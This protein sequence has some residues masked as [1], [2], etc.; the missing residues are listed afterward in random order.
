MSSY[1]A[2]KAVWS[3]VQDEFSKFEPLNTTSVVDVA[4]VGGGITGISAAYMLRKRGLSVVVLEAGRVGEGSTGSSTGNLYVPNARFRTILSKHKLEGLEAV[5]MSR[6]AAM[7]F[8]ED[9][10]NEFNIECGYR[11]VPMYYFTPW[12]RE[13]DEIRNERM[14]IQKGGIIASDLVPPDFPFPVFACTT[15]EMQAQF[16]PLQYVKKLA[17]ELNGPECVIH[18]KTKVLKITDGEPC[19][20]ETTKGVVTAR[21]VIQATHTPKGIYAVHAMMEVYREYAVA[22]RIKGDLPPDAI[23]WM[24]EGNQKYSIRTY[25]NETGSWLI[26]LDDSH[27]VGTKEKTG[28]SFKKIEKFI[29]S[30]FDVEEVSYMWAAQNYSSADS[31]PYI[32]TGPTEKNVYIATGFA[33]DGLTYGTAAA[34]IVTDLI[35][36]VGNPWAQY[37]DPKRLTIAASAKNAIKENLAVLSHLVKDYIFTGKEKKLVYVR[38]GKGKVVEISGRK[39]AAY[40]DEEGRF[41]I[42]DAV[43]PH[44]G[45]IVHWNSAEK[46]WDCPC[47]GSRFTIDGKVLEGPAINDLTQYRHGQDAGRDSGVF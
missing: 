21:H 25:S 22:L 43:C 17:A 28:K 29:R 11:R 13:V 30:F 34:M 32:G 39:A 46:S 6:A 12:K 38:R 27:S 2:T 16:N 37:F 19:L 4:I 15:I 24:N 36:G 44:M 10:I 20:V 5:V 47:H 3:S 35:T 40:R 33:A 23:Y 31:L 18:E 26:V 7:T 42:V 8:I 45:C 9:R 14:A 1:Q 41:H